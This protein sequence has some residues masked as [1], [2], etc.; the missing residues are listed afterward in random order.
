MSSAC[1]PNGL[2]HTLINAPSS[3]KNRDRSRYQDMHQTKKGNQW[4]FGMKAHIGVDS[5]TKVIN[6]VMAT[7]A[8]VADAAV[9][10]DL[11]HGDE[12]KLWGDQVYRDQTEVIRQCAPKAKDFTNRRYRHRG[13]VD[14]LER[15]RN[16]SKSKVR[17]KVE[18]PFHA[19][20][21]VFGFVK[22]CYK[23][24]EKNANRCRKSRICATTIKCQCVKSAKRNTSGRGTKRFDG[25]MLRPSKKKTA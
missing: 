4:Y 1:R 22:V 16:R 24:L 6:S 8:N 12:T 23:G 7:S 17:A 13:V 2:E 18:H 3:T 21:R 15:V 5:K 14:E 9:L 20:K 10:T 19:I 25:W 11:L